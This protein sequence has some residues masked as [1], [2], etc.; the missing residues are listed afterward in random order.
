MKPYFYVNV[1]QTIWAVL[2][3]AGAAAFI[4]DFKDVRSDVLETMRR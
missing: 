4:F 2:A 3:I 1:H